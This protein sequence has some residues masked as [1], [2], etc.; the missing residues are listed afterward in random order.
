M[1]FEHELHAVREAEGGCRLDLLSQKE[2]Q[3][4]EGGSPVEGA[5]SLGSSVLRAVASLRAD[6]AGGAR[7]QECITRALSE[8]RL[9][10]LH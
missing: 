2:Q 7:E 5:A 6:T 4:D 10:Y 3:T 1:A 8:T 9:Y